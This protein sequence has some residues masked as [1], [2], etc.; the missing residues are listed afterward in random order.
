MT[1]AECPFC[2]IIDGGELLIDGGAVVA[3]PDA[4]P[5]SKGH[6]LVVPRRHEAD[7][8]AL[9]TEEQAAMLALAVR[10]KRLLDER[11]QPQGYNLGVNAGSVAGQTIDHAHMHVVPRYEGDV[12]DPRGGVRWIIPG[13]AKYWAE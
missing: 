1:E 9:T 8:F 13:K 10:V 4:Y 5:I 11:F 7:Y 6:A 3:I 2:R 12:P